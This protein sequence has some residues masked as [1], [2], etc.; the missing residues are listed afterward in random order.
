[1]SPKQ[2][3]E[4][5]KH[6]WPRAMRAKGWDQLPRDQQERLRRALTQE[7]SETAPGPLTDSTTLLNEDQI[8]ALWKLLHFYA[9]QIDLDA[10]IAV[11]NPEQ[12]RAKDG[13]GRLVY[14]INECGFHRNYIQGIAKWYCR[15]ARVTKWEDLP[16]FRLRHL[17]ITANKMRLKKGMPLGAYKAEKAPRTVIQEPI[18]FPTGHPVQD[19]VLKPRKIF[20]PAVKTTTDEN[21]Y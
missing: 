5:W 21:P 2:R 3:D 14:K 18:Q 7:A 15:Q 13:A 12:T 17:L 10:A 16:A 11:A 9:A 6:L 4:Y 19:Y 8:T 1:M 20:T